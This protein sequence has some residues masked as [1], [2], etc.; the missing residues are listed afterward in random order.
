VGAHG[1]RR[2]RA[3]DRV[4]QRGE[5]ASRSRERKAARDGHSPCSRGDAATDTPAGADRERAPRDAR[6]RRG[7]CDCH[8]GR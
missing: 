1:H 2:V 8:V 6:R 5:S 3:A 7:A 4:R